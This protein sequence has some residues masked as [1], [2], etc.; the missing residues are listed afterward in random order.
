MLK[1]KKKLKDSNR[2]PTKR[3]MVAEQHFDDCGE[4]VTSLTGVSKAVECYRDSAYG[5]VDHNIAHY[6][7]D[8]FFNDVTRWL[9]VV[10]DH[11]VCK[12]PNIEMAMMAMNHYELSY[13]RPKYGLIGHVDVAEVMGG[14]KHALHAYSYVATTRVAEFLIVFAEW[15]CQ[16]KKRSDSCIAIFMNNNLSFLSLHPNAKA[17]RV[18]EDSTKLQILLPFGKALRNPPTL[19]GFVPNVRGYRSLPDDVSLRN[20]DEAVICTNWRAGNI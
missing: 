12:F 7:D 13:S 17:W 10:S 15:I 1:Y 19:D 6:C 11:D 8:L 16:D 9:G 5:C 18:G 20:N 4:D 14:G 3:K 2:K